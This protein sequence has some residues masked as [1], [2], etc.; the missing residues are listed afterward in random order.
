M[1]SQTN[2]YFVCVSLKV[3]GKNKSNQEFFMNCKC[4]TTEFRKEFTLFISR[5]TKQNY[6]TYHK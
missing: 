1:I 5:E 4:E 2:Y 3:Y 6:F